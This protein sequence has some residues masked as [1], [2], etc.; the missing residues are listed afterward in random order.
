MGYA[1]INLVFKLYLDLPCP[2]ALLKICHK[3]FPFA[4]FL[5][6]ACCSASVIVHLLSAI[7]YKCICDQMGNFF[8]INIYY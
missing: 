8:F 4:L 3:F 6:L 1:P 2:Y 5:S 7:E